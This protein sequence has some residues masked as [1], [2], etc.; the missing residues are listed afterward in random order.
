MNNKEIATHIPVL[1]DPAKIIRKIGHFWNDI[2]DA[3]LLVWGEHIHHGYYDEASSINT[4]PEINKDISPQEKLI[5]KIIDVVSISPNLNILDVGCG[6]AGSAIYLAENLDSHVI[7]VT[8]SSKQQKIANTKIKNKGIQTVEIRIDDAHNL[9]SIADGSCDI[10]WSLESC[11][12]FYDKEMFIKS[13]YRVLKPGGK[14][15]IATWCA[16]HDVLEGN[17]AKEY[18]KLCQQFDLPYMPSIQHYTKMLSKHF[19]VKESLDWSAYVKQSW[20]IGILKLKNYSTIQLLKIA[21]IRGFRFVCYLKL[22]SN[23]FLSGR[24]RYGVFVAIKS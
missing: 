3:W 19:E 15:M 10:V 18:L 7:G 9:K 17:P 4:T 8:L 13:A 22:M 23:A 2:S 20:E 6:M 5:Q 14:L 24:I 21:G 11:E 1:K 12:Q 16:E